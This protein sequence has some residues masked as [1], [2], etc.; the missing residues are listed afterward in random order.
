MI[1]FPAIDLKHGACV[2]LTR[3]DMN[4]ATIYNED[5]ASQARL[6]EKQ[7][8]SW[9]HI[10][11]LDGA[12]EGYAVNQPAVSSIL[13]AIKIP[14]QLG[15]GIRDM[16]AIDS[17]LDA[18]VARVILGTAAVKNP[19]LVRQAAHDYPGKI[20]IGIDARAGQVAVSGW[21]DT[22]DMDVL[23]L[24][25]QCEDWGV[26]AIIY[27]DIDR[28]GTGQGLNIDATKKL[29]ASITIPVIASGGVGSIQDIAAVRDAG[30][31]GA[32]VGK[33]LYDGRVTAADLLKAQG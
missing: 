12:A 29:A 5:P 10:V 24:A 6:F 26:A 18:G 33:A 15:G 16:A 28:D 1:V 4:A 11:D 31:A 23:T 22:T 7:G 25:K 8:F 32:I 19:K 21:V 30:L 13:Q 14:V 2:R 27:T 9:I 17:W 3:G 20:A